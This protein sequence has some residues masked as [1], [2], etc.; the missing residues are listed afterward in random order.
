MEKVITLDATM[1]SEEKYINPRTAWTSAYGKK[2]FHFI[3][4]NGSEVHVP[5]EDVILVLGESQ[6]E[7]QVSEYKNA[8]DYQID[9]THYKDMS[10]DPWEVQELVLTREEFIGGLK[11]QI[12]KY[13]M[14]QGKKEGSD[15]DAEKAKHYAR[16]L[17]EFLA[18]EK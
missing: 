14:R 10:I 11:S 17:R 5:E 3:D 12:I 16:K 2:V 9:G 1:M 18:N 4:V 13:A 6:N 7:E 8:D 15:H